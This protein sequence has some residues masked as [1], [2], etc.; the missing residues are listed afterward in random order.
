[1]RSGGLSYNFRVKPGQK[2][3]IL[4]AYLNGKPGGILKPG[5][6]SLA[7]ETWEA[8]PELPHPLLSRLTPISYMK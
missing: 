1:M 8:Y 2:M 7:F 3:G 4:S 5:S 6:P